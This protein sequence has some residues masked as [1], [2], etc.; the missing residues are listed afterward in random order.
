MKQNLE[1]I[2]K[3]IKTFCSNMFGSNITGRKLTYF[4]PE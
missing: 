1:A 4:H 2:T 3:V